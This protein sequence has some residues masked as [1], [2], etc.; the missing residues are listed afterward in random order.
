M[1][2]TG[3][4]DLQS[5]D[6]N[7]K[8]SRFQNSEDVYRAS[9]RWGEWNDLFHLMK[10]KPD[11]ADKLKQPSEDYLLH[12]ET[13]KVKEVTVI[14]SN[15]DKALGEGFS[16]FK[17]GYRIDSVLKLYSI[18][19]KVNWWY[20]KESNLWFT[21]TPLPKEFAPPKRRTIKL[22]PKTY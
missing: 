17:I 3:C 2:N 5:M 8:I 15:M 13:I 9:M 22:S 6:S 19:H 7:S 10:D 16:Q 21:D 11:A 1:F 14:G 4:T 18:R 12:L 20:H